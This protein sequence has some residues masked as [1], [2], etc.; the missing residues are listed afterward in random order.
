MKVQGKHQFSHYF[1]S[2]LP[3]AVSK[4][5]SKLQH[6]SWTQKYVL[7]TGGQCILDGIITSISFI[8]AHFLRFD[9]YPPGIEASRMWL[10]LPYMAA[11]RIGTNLLLGVYRRVW[12]YSSIADAVRISGSVSFASLILLILRLTFVG[13]SSYLTVPIGIIII[14]YC[15][16]TAGMV[17][18]RLLRRLIYEMGSNGGSGQPRVRRRVLLAGAG[19]A[20]IMTVRESKSRK[21]LGFD[22]VGFVDDDPSKIRAVIHGSPVLGMCSEIPEI[23]RKYRIELVIITMA[24]A[25]RKTVKQ[26]YDLCELAGVP[27]QITPGFYEI[28]ANK[29]SVSKLRSVEIEDLLGRDSIDF[30]SWLEATKTHYVNKRVLVTGAGGS[31]GRELCRQLVALQPDQIIMLDKDENAVYEADRDLGGTNHEGTLIIPIVADLRMPTQLRAA[32][33]SYQ[34]QIVFHAAAHKHVPLM[35]INVAEAI[36]NNVMGTAELLKTCAEKNVQRAVMVSTDKAVNPTSIMGA[37][38][39]V[40]ELLFQSYAARYDGNANY[41]CVRF[42]NVLGSRGSVVPLFREQ[43]KNGGPVTVTHPDMVRYFMTIPEAAQLIIQAGALGKKGEIFLLDMGEPVKIVDLAKDMIR[44]SGLSLGEEIELRFIGARPGEKIR[45]ELLIAKEGATATK[46]NKIFI[47]PALS[48]DFSKLA[49]SVTSLT[50]AAY[51]SNDAEI[52][53]LL[54]QMD[55]GFAVRPET[56]KMQAAHG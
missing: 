35:E 28:L 30:R 51:E 20:G 13:I 26:I 19:Q 48:Y 53:R 34:P 8:A 14:D 5:I 4:L 39:R 31:I 36:L 1:L 43:I 3:E 9:G 21:D 52:G 41:V 54:S 46:F 24:S 40:S 50:K 44:L 16:T 2:V 42:G 47:A 56:P 15:L 6:H 25:P 10:V 11:A 7:T 55:I 45:E 17:N 23:V 12:R 29:V 38:K 49:G 33:H 22:I 37:T 32:F 27:V 18:V